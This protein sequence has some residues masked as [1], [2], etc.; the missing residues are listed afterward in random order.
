MNRNQKL[1]HLLD[2][3]NE[4]AFIE[5]IKSC[6]IYDLKGTTPKG[7]NL[8]A[9]AA[10]KGASKALEEVLKRCPELVNQYNIKGTTPLHFS[11]I[12]G[13]LDCYRILVKYGADEKAL[14]DGKYSVGFNAI[15]KKKTH[16]FIE[17]LNNIEKNGSIRE[18]INKDQILFKSLINTPQ[19]GYSMIPSIWRILNNFNREEQLNLIWNNKA[20]EIAIEFHCNDI[21][22]YFFEKYPNN[23]M[24]NWLAQIYKALKFKNFDIFHYL[25]NYYFKGYGIIY[26]NIYNIND[27]D[28]HGE[29]IIHYICRFGC[30]DL[31]ININTNFRCNLDQKNKYMESP[32]QIANNNKF[33]EISDYIKSFLYKNDYTD[34]NIYNNN[35]LNN[36]YNNINYNNNDYNNSYNI[37]DQRQYNYNEAY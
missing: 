6:S 25:I 36:N 15:N 31:L 16:I 4:D 10:K 17:W 2:F 3:S 24:N 33:H 21:I 20:I 11:A 12:G 14:S 35:I 27:V 32:L 5:E 18:M 1:F 19:P 30:L 13:D 26:D 7:E 34:N 22:T 37:G 9:I 28:S 8:A 29:G 23:K